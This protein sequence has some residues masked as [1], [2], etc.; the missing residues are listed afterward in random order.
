MK[1]LTV[2]LGA[3]SLVLPLFGCGQ[4][5]PLYLPDDPSRIEAVPPAPADV[6]EEEKEEEAEAPQG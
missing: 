6:E 1:R 2:A 5:G 3:F 4:S